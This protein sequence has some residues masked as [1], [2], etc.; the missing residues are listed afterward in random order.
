MEGAKEIP[1]TDPDGLS[2]MLQFYHDLG[3]IIYYPKATSSLRD[4][5]ILDPQW[6]IE[7]FKS[8]ITVLDKDDRVCGQCSC[9]FYRLTI[10]FWQICKLPPPP[11][12]CHVNK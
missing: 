4:R 10:E 3:I 6:L 9:Y 12:L 11:S 5:I 1:A 2:T 8:V 7:V